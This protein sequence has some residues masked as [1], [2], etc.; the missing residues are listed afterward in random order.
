[1]HFVFCI[2]VRMVAGSEQLA[3]DDHSSNDDNLNY[4][5]DWHTWPS[6]VNVDFSSLESQEFQQLNSPHNIL[7]ADI[8]GISSFLRREKE[9]YITPFFP[10]KEVVLDLLEPAEEHARKVHVEDF[11]WS[12]SGNGNGLL[13]VLNV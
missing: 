6:S 3:L 7:P 12:G 5:V 8:G 9:E 4:S 1:M 2:L 11:L 10:V 13:S